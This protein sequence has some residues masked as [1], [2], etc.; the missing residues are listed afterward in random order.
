MHEYGAHLF[1]DGCCEMSNY[2]YSTA[3]V[4]PLFWLVKLIS[5]CLCCEYGTLTDVLSKGSST[6]LIKRPCN[7]CVFDF[8]TLVF[9]LFVSTLNFF[10]LLIQFEWANKMPVD[11][12]EFLD[13]ISILAEN[14]NMRATV[15]QSGKGALIAGA[16][17]FVGGLVGGPVGMAAGGTIGGITAYRMAGSE[18]YA[19]RIF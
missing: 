12:K 13:G 14:H 3:R 15:R 17:C 8:C 9:F 11:M 16:C 19:S 4:I 10:H 6:A 1:N 18:C 5:V 7:I 2:Y